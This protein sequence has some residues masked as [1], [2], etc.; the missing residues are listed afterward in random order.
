MKP[1]VLYPSRVKIYR[2][3]PQPILPGTKREDRKNSRLRENQNQNSLMVIGKGFDPRQNPGMSTVS[4]HPAKVQ[5]FKRR[6][7]SSKEARDALRKS[8]EL[9]SEMD[10]YIKSSEMKIPSKNK[11]QDIEKYAKTIENE[12]NKF[13]DG[14][15]K[16]TIGQFGKETL[17]HSKIYNPAPIK[18][19]AADKPKLY[20]EIE[21]DYK[22]KIQ[23]KMTTLNIE[24]R[25]IFDNI[26]IMKQSGTDEKKMNQ[27]I[28]KA[29]ELSRI[30]AKLS[31]DAQI[32]QKE[33]EN[34]FMR[35]DH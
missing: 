30:I 7:F 25:N 28:N 31:Q 4:F 1:I 18:S 35:E 21:G 2:Q 34:K 14:L 12:L 23:E 8:E 10:D 27:M 5:H 11:I 6:C 24:L 17:K 15:K 13:Q 32:A 29:K 22:K 3:E 16:G 33:V 9:Y 20:P 26:S 19:K